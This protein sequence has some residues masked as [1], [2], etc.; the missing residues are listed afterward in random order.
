MCQ[1]WDNEKV[2]SMQKSTLSSSKNGNP[3]GDKVGK[4]QYKFK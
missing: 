2:Q 1:D 3:R 4:M